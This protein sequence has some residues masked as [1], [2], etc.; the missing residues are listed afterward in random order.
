HNFFNAYF[1][2]VY[3][4]FVLVPA[5]FFIAIWLEFKARWLSFNRF[6]MPHPSLVGLSL[7]IAFVAAV[8][9]QEQELIEELVSSLVFFYSIRVYAYFR[10][11]KKEAAP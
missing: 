1:P 10:G 4:L 5:P 6:I 2:S 9:P 8:R 3:K 11:P 7:L